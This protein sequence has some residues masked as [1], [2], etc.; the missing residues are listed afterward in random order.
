MQTS[1]AS[2]RHTSN[3]R[4]RE[5]DSLLLYSLVIAPFTLRA[6]TYVIYE[7]EIKIATECV[8]HNGVI[9]LFCCPNFCTETLYGTQKKPRTMPKVKGE[10]MRCGKI[11]LSQE[12]FTELT[13]KVHLVGKR[14]SPRLHRNTPETRETNSLSICLFAAV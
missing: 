13:H 12:I 9:S 5:N 10:C 7:N 11:Q 14:L 3:I 2:S 8:Q 6:R 1:N 4:S